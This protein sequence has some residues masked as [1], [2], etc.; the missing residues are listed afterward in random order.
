MS[1]PGF[2]YF[3]NWL[4][5]TEVDHIN[6]DLQSSTDWVGVTPSANS[7]QV[8]QYG[9]AYKYNPNSTSS[10]NIKPIPPIYKS[11][12]GRLETL[13]QTLPEINTLNTFDQIIINQYLS[14]QGIAPHIDNT[15][16]FGSVIA[17]VS[18]GSGLEIE[19]TRPN[20]ESVKVYVEPNS[21]YIMSG[22]ARYQYLHGIAKRKSDLINGTKIIRKT[23]TSLTFRSTK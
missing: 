19:F 12:I 18:L 21:V 10:T 22:E 1:I 5:T 13:V 4:S 2:Y 9:L 3:P 8:I 23:R 15:Q 17:C 14:G 6:N 20:Y 11:I 16:I 7:R